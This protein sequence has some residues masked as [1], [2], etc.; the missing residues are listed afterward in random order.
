[1]FVFDCRQLFF[2]FSFSETNFI[3]DVYIKKTHYKRKHVVTHAT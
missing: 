3:K 2:D 1:M